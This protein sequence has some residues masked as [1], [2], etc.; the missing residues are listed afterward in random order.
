MD[1]TRTSNEWIT[2]IGLLQEDLVR[3][4]AA[5]R[6]RRAY[7]VD[8]EQFVHWAR[9]QHLTLHD[10]GPKQVRRYIA[11]LSELGAAP[12]TSA[13]KLAAIRALF[14]SQRE[15]G[16]IAEN[17]A[18]LV[19]PPRR[20]SYL[21]RVLSAREAAGLL[22]AIPASGPLELRDRAMFELA[23]A[24]G[25]R[26]EELVSLSEADVSWDEEQLRVEGKGRK[27]RFVPG[28]EPAM[29]ALNAYLRPENGREGRPSLTNP[30]APSDA[31]FLSKTGRPLGTSDVRRRL[32]MW[33]ARAGAVAERAGG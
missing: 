1:D 23:Y 17:P 32:R 22:D 6:T 25:L 7:G 20:G 33:T 8:L 31:I 9:T 27:T 2:A 13:R 19:S 30:G 3:R 16:K 10:T 18:D 14:A 21:P 28:G 26:A 29:K 15:H 5:E 24:C 11:H 12:S 4:D